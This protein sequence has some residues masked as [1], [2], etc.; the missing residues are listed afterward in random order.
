MTVKGPVFTY[1]LFEILQACLPVFFFALFHQGIISFQKTYQNRK[2]GKG[3]Q[4]VEKSEEKAVY[5]D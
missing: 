4:A 1:K 3:R 5:N 2:F